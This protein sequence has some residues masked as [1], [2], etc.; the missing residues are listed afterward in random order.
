MMAGGMGVD[1]AQARNFSTQLS[2]GSENLN[3]ILNRT[4]NIV[5]KTSQVYQGRGSEQFQQQFRTLSGKFNNFYDAVQR[6]AIFVSNMADVN[7]LAEND[8]ARLAQ[9]HLNT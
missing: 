5:N 1:F 8:V 3:A 6:Y 9:Q 2:R 7:E 4:T